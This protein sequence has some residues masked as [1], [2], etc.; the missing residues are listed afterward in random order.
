MG[1]HRELRFTEG[2]PDAD[3]DDRLIVRAPHVS[4]AGV[5]PS[6]QEERARR[7]DVR[8]RKAEGSAAAR[9]AHDLA[10][11]G[12]GA[13]EQPRRPREVSPLERAPDL[14]G[15]HWDTVDGHGGDDVRPEPELARESLEQRGVATGAAAEAVVEADDN[16]LRLQGPHDHAPD[17][18]LRFHHGDS[19]GEGDDYGRVDP[20][21]GDQLE[22]LLEG[23]D[24][25]RRAL[26]L[27]H[28][29]RVRIERAREGLQAGEPRLSHGRAEDRTMAQV[30]AVERAEHDD[31]RV[32]LRRVGLESP[33]DPHGEF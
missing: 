7:P 15:R 11:D 5:D 25:D 19:A 3:V 29:E 12:V 28:L 27:E 10:L 4:L 20:G 21:L 33:D 6:G 31:A 16:V 30:D 14:R 24:G 18:V 2:G 8:G 1:L 23:G 22:P 17:E 13:P 26:G 9:A 32:G